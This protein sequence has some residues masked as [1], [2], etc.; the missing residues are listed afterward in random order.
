MTNN[1]KGFYRNIKYYHLMLFSIILSL[2]L[3]INSN[4]AKNK[5]IDEKLDK[6]AEIKFNKILIGRH[7]KVQTLKKEWKKFAIK[8]QMN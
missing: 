6:E 4:N 3:I 8:E 1:Q 5:R 2:L 7:L